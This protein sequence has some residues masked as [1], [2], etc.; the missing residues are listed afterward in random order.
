MRTSI[1]MPAYSDCTIA[2]SVL[3]CGA[4]GISIMLRSRG[5]RLAPP[6]ANAYAVEPLGK[7]TINPSAKRMEYIL[8][9]L[10]IYYEI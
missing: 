7:S 4:N 6:A 5:S 2:L 1:V 3:T 9:N 8:L 10:R